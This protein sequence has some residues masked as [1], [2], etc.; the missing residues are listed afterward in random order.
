MARP[1]GGLGGLIWRASVRKGFFGNSRLWTTIFAVSAA[2]KLFRRIAGGTADVV[3]T[4][5]LAPGQALLITH[6][7]DL[8]HGDKSR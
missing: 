7:A 6:H 1:Q 3:Y 8:L 2:M 5:E 4:E